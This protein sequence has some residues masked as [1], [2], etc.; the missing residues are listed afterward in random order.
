M[1]QMIQSWVLASEPPTWCIYPGKTVCQ[2]GGGGQGSFQ[3]RGQVPTG[4]PQTR[5]PQAPLAG[6]AHSCSREPDPRSLARRTPPGAP[7]APRVG[8]LPSPATG[9]GAAD[10]LYPPRP[11]S[12]AHSA[13]GRGRKA[14]WLRPLGGANPEAELSL[15]GIRTRPALWVAHFRFSAL[16]AALVVQQP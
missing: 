3:A 9:P 13:G 7:L 11:P 6:A 10:P 14:G 5:S 4:K 15:D 8:P 2:A 16:S 1:Q 12:A